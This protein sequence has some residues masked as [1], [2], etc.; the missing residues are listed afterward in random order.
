[1]TSSATIS[2]SRTICLYENWLVATGTGL[3][4]SMQ[5]QQTL[6]PDAHTLVISQIAPAVTVISTVVYCTELG[7]RDYAK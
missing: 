6:R 4:G 7:V 1:M 5:P 3:G 2:R